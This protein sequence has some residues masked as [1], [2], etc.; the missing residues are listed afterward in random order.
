M[1]WLHCHKN[2]AFA[3][4]AVCHIGKLMWGNIKLFCKNLSVPCSLIEHI[5]KVT[6]FKNIFNFPACQQVFNILRD[7]SRDTS[8]TFWSASRFPRYMLQ[9]VLLSEANG[10]HLYNI[11]WTYGHNGWS[12]P[13]SRP[14][15]VQWASPVFKLLAQVFDVKTD[16]PVIQFHIRL[17]VK[18]L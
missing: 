2:Q 7:P 4:S 16:N 6:V 15:P 8:P 5:D 13:C 1:E 14:D 11:W 18:Y 9:S 3:L 12:L 17:M 10:T